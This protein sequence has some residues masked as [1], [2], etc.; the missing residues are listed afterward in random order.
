MKRILLTCLTAFYYSVS[1][2]VGPPQI[3]SPN[4][5]NGYGFTQ[6]VGTYAPLSAGRTVW[7]S[8]A[9]L[10]TDLVSAA[11]PLPSNFTYNNQKYNSVYISNNG[12]VTLGGATS[13]T[14][15][16]GLSSEI[17][18]TTHEAAFAGFGANL[19]N[20]NTTSSEISYE[21]V[22]T[23]FIVQFTDVQ[24]NSGSASQLLNFQIQLD[25]T[26]HTVA[27]VYGNCVSG[28]ST[29]T[30]QVG[31]RGS[32][33]SDINNLTGTNWTSLTAGTTA[34]SSSTLGTTNGTTVPASGLTFTYTP[35]TWLAAPNTFATLP[36]TESFSTW[37]NG[38]STLDLPNADYWRTWPARGD[39]SWR[40]SD[41][42]GSGFASASGW[43]STSGSVT[44][45][46]SAVAPA[47][48]FHSYN[49]QYASGYMDLYINLSSGSGDRILSFDYANPSGTDVLKIQISTD[50][51]VTFTDVGMTFGSTSST[52]PWVTNYVNLASSSPNAIIR[53]LAKGDNGSDDIY[54]DNINISSVNVAPNCS[55]IT[56]PTNAATGLSITPNFKWDASPNATSY[57][58]NLGTTSG[59]SNVM[60]GVDVG[61]VLT[62]TIPAASQLLYGTTYYATI[63]PTNSTGTASGCTEI[64]FITK[65]IGCPTVT[66]PVS[67]ASGVSVMPTITWGAVTDATGYKI[68]VGTTAGGTDVM[69]S[70]DVGNITSYTLSSALN[71]STKY[72]YTVNAY[73]PTS[74]SASC[75]E[76]SFTTVCGSE[77]IPTISQGFSTLTPVCWSVAK[78]DVT[79]N[80]TLTYGSSKWAA[81]SGFANT[82]NNTAVKLNL[83]GTN[84]GDWLISQPINLG[85]T[86]GANRIRYRMAV[87][88]YTGTTAQ[89]TLG[90]HQV[91]VII[92]TDGGTTWSN[93]NV[94]KTYTG[95][96]TYSNTGQTE[97]VDL[98]AYSGT[99]KVA[100]VATTSSTSPD[101]YF[102]LDDFIVEPIPTCIEPDSP[103][104]A[105]ITSAS[106]DLSWNAPASVPANGYEYYYS[107]NST[108]PAANVTI[109]GTSTATS[110]VLNG[111]SS[112]TTYYVWVRSACSAANKSIWSQAAIFT[113]TCT[114]L[115]VYSQ[116]FDT[117]PVDTL[118]MCWTSIGTVVGNA[119]VSAY[120]TTVASAPN[121]LYIYSSSS[122][123]GMVS[124]PEFIGLDSNTATISFKGRA[125]FTAGGIV[126]IGYL[127]N[128]ADTST[129][130]VLDSYTASN[131]STIDNYSLN[132]MGVPA[133]INK[134]V[135][136]HTGSPANSVLID[137][138]VYQFGSLSTSE[139]T[140]AK[141]EIKV[142]PNPFSDTLNISDISK[143]Q[144]VSV[145]DL[146]GRVVK[147]IEKPSSELHLADLKQ[148]MYLVVLHMKDGSKQVVKSIKK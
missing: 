136:R 48:R 83:Y 60:A 20:A 3:T 119:K 24:S 97:T 52:S 40:Q 139:V 37:A 2:Q 126:E 123:V 28:A 16:T 95:A 56:A 41:T 70:V 73:T 103:V 31:I 98:A 116:N 62:Y 49:C 27:I 99:V 26:S 84:T 53:F 110:T 43:T 127:T 131:I 25:L 47:A 102:H 93:T 135:F 67:G 92:S 121:A 6:S 111:L 69:N 10:A 120:S 64:S 145:V 130:V 35:G 23:K 45:G 11:I 36:F 114:P 147:T 138:F 51:G 74:T 22:G 29:F 13:A 133:G 89:S 113:T 88:S 134:L 1:A 5:N 79:A 57:K 58:L 59:G 54:V 7:Q 94:L 117:T 19:R 146:A 42:S 90:T 38:N 140:T 18:P 30:G 77:N 82:G 107:T 61:N 148:G 118:P 125:N 34:T 144:S 112:A 66:L 143:V 100:F 78:G 129:F 80:S 96:G 39:N 91:R 71:Y 46:G 4:T 32:E 9:T 65:N 109:S 115:Q 14:T 106:S 108:V 132:I 68:S 76:R 137:N 86:P 104:V 12:F 21:T 8:G 75:T 33:A 122:G 44:I 55:T 141:N 85:A 63:L 17:T 101:I 105:N 87:T 50:N 81:A 124:T 142:Y 72:Y 128:P 15:Y